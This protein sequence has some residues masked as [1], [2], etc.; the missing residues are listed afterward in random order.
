MSNI[1]VRPRN[2]GWQADFRYTDPVTGKR[3]RKQPQCPYPQKKKSIAWAQ[4]YKQ[5]LEAPPEPEQLEA[6]TLLEFWPRYRDT[7]IATLKPSTANNQVYKVEARLLPELGDHRLDEID[8]WAIDSYI[9]KRQEEVK[10]KTI[11]NEISILSGMLRRARRWGLLDGDL[12]EIEWPRV[13]PPKWRAL[14]REETK[15][16]FASCEEEPF[17]ERLAPFLTYTGLRLGEALALRWED[18]DLKSCTMTV[19][20]SYSGKATTAP[21]SGKARHLPL[22]D[23]A[24][25]ILK[26]QRT[27]T[28]LLGGLVF[29]NE[30]G[31]QLRQPQLKKPWTRAI[32]ASGI[33]HA[34]VHD[35]RHTHASWLAQAG[36]S[37]QSIKELL[38]HS[39]IRTTLRYAHLCTSN[40][41]G[42]LDALEEN[43]DEMVTSE[44]TQTA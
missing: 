17:M 18:I 32:K 12:P 19:C 33:K 28:G 11:R 3:K 13:D 39:D 20:R 15:A 9:A 5:Q 42:A 10:N 4:E 35:L 40:L 2:G 29:C 14:T 41:E 27:Q 44:G 23:T 8:A 31:T 16:L 1:K 22:A 34:R 7:H 30:D 37:L 36:V 26:E 43:G 25:A 38:G 6:P 24:V 21:K